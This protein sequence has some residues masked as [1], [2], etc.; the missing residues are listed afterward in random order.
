MDL[1][2]ATLFASL[3]VSS[4]GLFVFMRGKQSGEPH[5]LVI[6][7]GLMGASYAAP[8]P[9]A[10]YSVAVITLGGWW[11]WGRYGG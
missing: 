5:E 4:I 2:P 1:S 10:M 3:V 9:L 6:G 7:L 8:G 11:A